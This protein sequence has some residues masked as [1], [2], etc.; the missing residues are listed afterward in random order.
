MALGT[1]RL[2]KP[3]VVLGLVWWGAVNRYTVVPRLHRGRATGIGARLDGRSV[4]PDV[5]KSV[6][7]E[8]VIDLVAFLSS[9]PAGPGH[10]SAAP[11]P[12]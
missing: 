10:S 11:R 2:M 1:R 12:Q 7:M 3:L 4:M 8:E 5:G 6:S 9:L